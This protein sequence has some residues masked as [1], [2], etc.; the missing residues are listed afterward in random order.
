MITLIVAPPKTGK[1]AL[2]C[3]FF[4]Q[5]AFNFERTKLGKLSLKNALAEGFDI[6]IPEHFA[7]SSVRM[8]AHCQGFKA[9]E[10]YSIDPFKI[11]LKNN[12]FDTV[13][14]PEY[15]AIFIPEGQMFFNS[16]KRLNEYTSAW[17]QN[18]GHGHYDVYIDGQ[19]VTLFDSNIRELAT[20]CFFVETLKTK[21]DRFGQVVKVIIYAIKFTDCN[22]LEKYV[23]SGKKEN[24]GEKAQFVYDGNIFKD[25]DAFENKRF[26]YHGFEKEKIRFGKGAPHVNYQAP[27]GWYEKE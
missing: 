6:E 27:K 5:E 22:S 3:Y 17:F 11:G 25:Y 13:F 9:R 12:K 20:Q 2:M 15:S 18:S 1:G 19:R 24:N 4:Q 23:S 26:F 16:R 21:T 8:V 10:N 7:F 14:I